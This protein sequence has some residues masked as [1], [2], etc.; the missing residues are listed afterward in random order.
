LATGFVLVM[1]LIE[2]SKLYSR[3]IETHKSDRVKA[4]ELQRLATIDALTGMVACLHPL[5]RMW[6]SRPALHHQTLDRER[7]RLLRSAMIRTPPR[8]GACD[9]HVVHAQLLRYALA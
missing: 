9:V 6:I 5:A 7:R 4:A 8:I 1:L 3:L 2:N